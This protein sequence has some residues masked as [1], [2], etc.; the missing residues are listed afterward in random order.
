MDGTYGTNSSKYS[1][2]V[3]AA[4]NPQFD[5]VI[6]AM[7]LLYREDSE[8][9]AEFLEVF[10]KYNAIENLQKIVIDKCPAEIAA[11]KEKLPNIAIIL[12]FFHNVMNIE[13]NTTA[14]EPFQRLQIANI[15]RAMSKTSSKDSF[16]NLLEELKKIADSKFMEYFEK[17]WLSCTDMWAGHSAYF[18]N[19]LGNTTNNRLESKNGKL[20]RITTST[21]RMD[22]LLQKLIDFLKNEKS[23]LSY[24]KLRSS[25]TVKKVQNNNCLLNLIELHYP[26]KLY[27]KCK[28]E[29]E[30]PSMEF[31][32][33]GKSSYIFQMD[34]ALY[35]VEVLNYIHISI[36]Q[37]N[38]NS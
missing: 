24:S 34:S 7:G 18:E 10:K 30:K 12:C 22:N 31:K 3:L 33:A 36:Y 5:T 25:M 37:L 14:F 19:I 38:M 23:E 11:I 13:K 29:S 27:I 2:Y 15:F 35:N 16:N 28:S 21:D 32:R 8:N 9:I 26:H 17:N 20:K 1:L 4:Q 6:I